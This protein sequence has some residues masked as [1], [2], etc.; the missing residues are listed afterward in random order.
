MIFL[1]VHTYMIALEDTKGGLRH[2]SV[3][4]VVRKT[5]VSIPS[6]THTYTQCSGVQIITLLLSLLTKMKILEPSSLWLIHQVMSVIPAMVLWSWSSQ[7][8]P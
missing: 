2:R 8:V 5:L 4:A 1:N 6:N 3:M 7:T